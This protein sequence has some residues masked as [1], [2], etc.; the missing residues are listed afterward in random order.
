MTQININ[1]ELFDAFII[2]G[3]NSAPVPILMDVA[4]RTLVA[5]V[6]VASSISSVQI[7]AANTN[8]KGISIYNNSTAAL[9]LSYAAPATAANSFMQMQPGSLL[10]LDQQLIVSNAIYGIWTAA[11]GSAQVTQY[12]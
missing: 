11:N 9:F 6:S 10:M 8:R 1:G 12:T 3:Q 7:V 2:R 5:T 4:P